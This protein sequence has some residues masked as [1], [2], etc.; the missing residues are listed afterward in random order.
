MESSTAELE[1][2]VCLDLLKT[3][4]NCNTCRKRMCRQHLPRLLN[5]CPNCRTEPLATS[6]NE[7]LNKRVHEERVNRLKQLPADTRFKCKLPGCPYESH[8]K[9]MVLH[10]KYKH[11]E[12]DL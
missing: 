7:D 5:R 10:H 9:N 2:I 11:P 4:V 8:I 6:I 1:C 12:S 3:P